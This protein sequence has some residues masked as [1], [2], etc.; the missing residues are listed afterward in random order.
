VTRPTHITI[1]AAALRHNVARVK[2][3]CPQQ[4]IM[5][6]VKAN[7]YGCGVSNVVP[8]LE[9]QVNAFGV[10]CLEEAMVVRQMTSR[11]CVL[12]QGIFEKDEWY[13]V[14]SLGLQCVIHHEL[15]LQW[16]LNT[17]LPQPIRVWV[18]VNTGMQRLGFLPAAV[19]EVMSALN[20]CAWVDQPMGLMTHLACADDLASLQNQ[21][22]FDTF[23]AMFPEDN[24]VRSLANSAVILSRP[25]QLGA[26]VRPGIMLYGVSPFAARD[27]TALD[28][29]P[30]MHF[31]SAVSAIHEC[32][33]NTP[34]G[35]GGTWQSQQK[36]RIGVV[37]AGYGDGYPRHIA[38]GTPTAVNGMIAP[39][40][41]RVSM[42]MLTINLTDCPEVGIG[43]AVELWGSQI[44]V[45]RI[46]RQAGT[47]A[48]ELICQVSSRARDPSRDNHL[49]KIGELR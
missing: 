49:E 48:Y 22:Q 35:Y 41:G 4:K 30:V 45:E 27:G 34:V 20:D 33:P 9:H 39:I 26:V 5:A 8:V 43:D 2:A 29:K 46:A 31:T 44:P 11:D 14:A 24:F 13:S 18:K 6:M 28:L 42:D 12:M 15:Q 37:A 21:A 36:T 17:P 32:P 38:P 23:N 7:A 3:L 16:L 47:I 19:H 1:D 10:A 40:V 25:D